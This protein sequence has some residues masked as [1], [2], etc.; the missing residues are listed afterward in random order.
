MLVSWTTDLPRGKSHLVNR[1]DHVEWV[2]KYLSPAYDVKESKR[3]AAIGLLHERS[4]NVFY[5]Y[6]KAMPLTI[7]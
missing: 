7:K 6:L 1:V 3:Y 2:V 5:F 4:M